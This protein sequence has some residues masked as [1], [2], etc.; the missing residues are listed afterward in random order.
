MDG[1]CECFYGYRGGD[2]A[3]LCP[4]RDSIA[5]TGSRGWECSGHGI[6][7]MYPHQ[8]CLPPCLAPIP[9]TFTLA[10]T[11]TPIYKLD[12]ISVTCTPTRF[13]SYSPLCYLPITCL[14]ACTCFLFVDVSCCSSASTCTYTHTCMYKC[15]YMN[16]YV[17]IRT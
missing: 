11:L 15:V 13:V 12:M 8:V 17:H 14:P 3:H 7:D 4:G 9:T 6:C 5:F 16:V 10:H 2:C 1:R